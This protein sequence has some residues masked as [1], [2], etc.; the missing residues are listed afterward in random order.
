[1]QKAF[2]VKPLHDPAALPFRN[3]AIFGFLAI[4]SWPG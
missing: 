3:A 1:M 4:A 2:I